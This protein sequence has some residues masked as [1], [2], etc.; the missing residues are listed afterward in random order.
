MSVQAKPV[1]YDDLQDM[2]ASNDAGGRNPTGFTKKLIVLTAIMWSVFQL[3]YTSPFPYWLQE[4]VRNMGLNLNVVIDD[5][6]ARSVHLAFA[7]FLAYLSFP[8]FA[9]SPKHRVPLIDWIYATCGAFLG[10]YYLFFY[11]GLVTRFGAPNMQDIIAGCL[12][13][14]L[15]LEACRRSL[16]LPLV[17]I[18]VVFLLYNYFGQFLPA[19]WIISHR[20]GSLSQIINQQWI[21]TEGVFGVALG[22]STKYVFLFVLF[23][24][25][26]DK[27]GAGNYFIK[28]AFAYLGH[29]SGGPGK[30]AVVSS[31][32][33]GLVSGSSIANVVTTGT[34][35][36]PMM[37][38]VGLTPEKAGAIE[39]ASSVNG[40]I[41]PPVMGAA[42][43]LMIEY[44]NMPYSQL[45]VHAFL[46]ALISYIA[47][48][49]IVHLE[50]QKMG[51]RGLER[52]EPVSPIAVTFLKI[53][54]YILAVV[55]LAMA[56][57]YGLGWIKNISPDLAFPIVSL[58]LAAVYLKLISRVAKFPDLEMDDPNAPVA[59][60]PYRKPTV[61]AGL[62]F[63][64]PVVV[65]MWCLMV[66]Q[67]SPGLSAFWGTVALSI[68]LITQRPLLS[69]FRKNGENKTAL[70]KQGVQELVDGLESGARNMIGIGI[71]TATAG[72]IVG[73]VSLTG[74]GVQLSSIIE[75]LSMGNILLMLIL[76]AVF[77]L[78]LGMGLPTT[79]NYIVV[80]SLMALVIVEVG[81]QNG[82]IVPLIAVHLFVFYF[83]IMADVTPPVGL[84]SFAAAAISGGSP[85]KTGVQA[86]YY[87]L[88]TAIL[89][90]LFIFNTD[91][92]LIDVGWGK[93]I[94]IFI[95]STIGIIV[96]T[97]ATMNFFFTKNKLWESLILIFAAFVLF[98]PGFFMEYVSPTARH[99]EPAQLVQEIA[100]TPVG[101]NLTIKVSG[102]NPYGKTIEFYSQLVVPE[103]EDGESRIK[104]LGLTL[105]DTGEQIEI[106]GN[107]SPKILIDN[108]EID[109]PA[110]KAGLNWDQ[111]VLDV[112]LPQ[113]SLPKELMFIPALL[114]IFG[115]AWNQRR[116]KET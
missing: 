53:V 70:F 27:A 22:V 88:R 31:G 86:F 87:S 90:F 94:L 73:A 95:I 97:A 64:L 110:A 79:A 5:T 2:V 34:F 71:A 4:V 10:A 104:A 24:A 11:E 81:K 54:S 65:L 75:M 30:A 98:R 16:G 69:F 36:I 18:A 42:A 55:V 77:S 100:K 67:F 83:G 101:Q 57:Y 25:L 17:I 8:A 52:V 106:N 23:G 50:A 62:H 56:V 41:M 82:L 68:I 43:F 66:E 6:K 116:R 115:V 112:A 15:L 39:V 9:T 108:V 96:F 103:G 85:I 78:I 12:G 111:T 109:S 58:L 76:V 105:L 72:I 91:L 44:V 40:Q 32:L 7:L 26:L 113:N 107:P 59:K 61:N 74:F 63:L 84:A 38:R 21:T 92:L 13:I 19:S 89:P 99:I 28:T 20:S 80:S 14:L 33:T 51:L 102:L 37:K 114:L 46:P 1:D 35:T 60:L 49:Y 45:I 48:V 29:F 93:G 47:L 3:Y